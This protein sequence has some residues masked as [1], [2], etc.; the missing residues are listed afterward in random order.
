MK[1]AKRFSAL[2]AVLLALT[3]VLSACG[4]SSAPAGTSA[5]NAPSNAPA[6]SDNSEAGK[7]PVTVEFWTISHQPAFTDLYNRLIA[8]Y[9]EANPHVT[10]KWVDL[11]YTAIHEKLV[12]A[13]A[14]GTAPDVVNL[15]SE[16]ALSL[17]SEGALV[18]LNV[19]ATEE[20]RGIY[21]E[22][23]YNSCSIG[24]S[25][26]AFP[27]FLAVYIRMEPGLK[28]RV[29]C[30]PAYQF[31]TLVRTVHL[32]LVCF[33]F[34]HPGLC[35][36]LIAKPPN[37]QQPEI[38]PQNRNAEPFRIWTRLCMAFGDPILSKTFQELDPW[39]LEVSIS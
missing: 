7:E 30:V 22:S 1:N 15:N 29:P 20:Q 10:V 18:D 14:G 36:R 37:S 17:A 31:G 2:L 8:E 19:E 25:V 28:K 35:S 38:V 5:T 32:F 26:Y 34:Y 16:F 24:D 3:I 21:I 9:E 23:L 11:P 39:L 4:G 33:L 6:Q 27:W 12:T 13:I